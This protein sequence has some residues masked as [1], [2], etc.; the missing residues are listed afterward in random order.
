MVY[1][2]LHDHGMGD[3]YR[4]DIN[5]GISQKRFGIRSFD[6]L[7]NDQIIKSLLQFHEG[8][9]S[10]VSFLL[11]QIHCSACLWLLEHLSRFD[12]GIIK[13]SVNFHSKKAIITFRD[14]DITLRSVVELL[15]KIGYEPSINY[16]QL[17][18]DKKNIK[19]DKSLIYKLGMAG[20]AFG[21]IMLLSF[22]EYLG[23]DKASYLFHIGYINIVLAMPVMFYSGVDYLRSAYRGLK[24]QEFNI[25]LPIALGMIALFSRSIYDI[26]NQSGEGYLDSFAGFVF[27]LLIGRW[28]Q[29]FTYQALDFDRNYKS[30][31]PISATVKS[32]SEWISVLIRNQEL[33]P[34]D[35]IL[36]KGKARLNYSFVTGE[37]N[38]ITKEEGSQI[39]AGARHEGDSI[40]IEIIKKV[41]QSYLTQLWN[42]DTF[43]QHDKSNTS[44]LIGGISKYFTYAVIGIATITLLIWL[45]LDPSMAVNTF[46]A[47]LIVACPCVLA[48]SI[49]FTY[50][51]ILRLLARDGYYLRNVQTIEHIQDIDYIIFDKTGT[52]TDSKMID[53]SYIGNPLD[54]YDQNMI[55]SVCEQSAHPLSKA[56]SKYL[57]KTKTLEIEAYTEIIGSGLSASILGK[58]IRIGSSRFIFDTIDDNHRQGVFIEIDGKYLGRFE[59]KH[60]FRENVE[61]IIQSLDRKYKLAILSGD[62]DHESER[63]QSLVGDHCEVYFNQSPKNKL[64]KIKSPQEEGYKVMMIG[65]GLNDAGA[66]NQ[67][68]VGMVISDDENN[69]SPACDG[70]VEAS[71]F[72]KLYD[73]LTYLKAAKRI[74]YGAFAMAFMYNSIGLYFAMSGQLSPV[75]SAIIMP[76]SSITVII[77]GVVVSW[78]CYQKNQK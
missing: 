2:L 57:S 29:S 58:D 59:F 4:Y 66:L 77:Y 28:F 71:K 73:Q 60:A 33:I 50:G 31:F 61:S 23:F 56:I 26:I 11:P 69:F 46:T 75:I 42:E 70:I 51:N 76:L 1:T 48:L 65:D 74:I 19:T 30:Y 54:E 34:A 68:N 22:P 49:P 17:D 3:Y 47:V 7:D 21:N 8:G 63:I 16:D 37:S 24:I 72:S 25:D 5:P 53:I 55:I 64:D 27:F 35:S 41:N 44:K 36:R 52:I 39:F 18:S 78:I 9:I 62:T 10:K 12:S 32:G 43:K 67:A 6:Y 45:K 20:F 15:T 14:E 40:E 13:S 38:I